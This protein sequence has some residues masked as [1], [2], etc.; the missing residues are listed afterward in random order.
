MKNFIHIFCAQT[1]S[2]IIKYLSYAD[3]L[4]SIISFSENPGTNAHMSCTFFNS[5]LVVV[6]HP[7]R[8][9]IHINI[10]NVFRTNVN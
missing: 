10:I 8:K 7:H 4:N 9:N 2:V 1:I 3:C 5:N 6:G